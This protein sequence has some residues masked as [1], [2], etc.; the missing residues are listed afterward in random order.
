MLHLGFIVR[1]KLKQLEN[2]TLKAI[3]NLRRSIYIYYRV[4]M[5]KATVTFSSKSSKFP[6]YQ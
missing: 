4:F 1:L 3:L 6:F 2:E 5:L